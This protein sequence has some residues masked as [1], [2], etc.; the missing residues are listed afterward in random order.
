MKNIFFIV[1]FLLF[2]SFIGSNPYVWGHT[3]VT[4]KEAKDMIDT[5]E[6]LIVVD[7]REEES[8]YCDE[9]PTPPVPPGHIPGAVN[10]PWASGVLE[11]KYNELPIGGEILVLCRSGHRSDPAASFL[12]AQGFQHV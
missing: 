11:D 4:P 5:N 9:D 10:Y 8:E 3:D 6:E 12:D 2:T 7:V 1:S